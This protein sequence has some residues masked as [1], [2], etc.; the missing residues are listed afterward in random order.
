[1][2]PEV[3]DRVVLHSLAKDREARYQ[4][5]AEFRAD[6]EAASSGRAV[7]AAASTIAMAAPHQGGGGSAGATTEFIAQPPGAT[8]AM[9]PIGQTMP[10]APVGSGGPGGPGY[11]PGTGDDGLYARRG[12][13]RNAGGGS[14]GGRRAGFIALALAVV[15]LFAGAAYGVSY[16]V[17]QNSGAN[18]PVSVPRLVGLTQADAVAQLQSA[19]LSA[20]TIT[21]PSD[22]LGQGRVT[23]T[24]PASGASIKRGSV[25]QVYVSAGASKVK[26]PDVK[27]QT[28]DAATA[29]LKQA[30]FTVAAITDAVPGLGVAKDLVVNT[31]PA[32]GKLADRGSLITLQV[33]S[34]EV[35]VPD[36]VGKTDVQA[37]ALLK[38]AGIQPGQILVRQIPSNEPAGRVLRQDP[39]AGPQTSIDQVQI[40][41]AV[42]NPDQPSDSGQPGDSP[43]PSDS[44]QGDQGN[45][46]NQG[47]DQ[48]TPAPPTQTP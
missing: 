15:A 28:T 47:G 36:V 45:Q 27:G 35:E 42:P 48:G 39:A 19:G 10:Q 25:V 24:D 17:G 6:V 13:R 2:I 32:I 14:A 22:S 9:S 38:K 12:D 29:A 30:G 44:G 37:I 26:V 5:A 31:D 7:A 34:G 1:V 3:V 18:A 16:L 11:R 41:V 23:R 46:D 20:K 21:E 8:R 33:S 4:T 43:S 40:W